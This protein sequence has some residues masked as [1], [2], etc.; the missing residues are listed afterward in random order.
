MIG[1]NPIASTTIADDIVQNSIYSS[2]SAICSFTASGTGL[3]GILGSGSATVGVSAAGTGPAFSTGSA[4][5]SFGASGV[6]TIGINGIGSASIGISPGIAVAQVGISGTGSAAIHV[7]ASPVAVA[8]ITGSGSA[9]VSVSSLPSPAT[10]TT[11]DTIAFAVNCRTMMGSEYSSF[12]F[13]SLARQGNDYFAAGSGGIYKL[14]G[15]KDI[16]ANIDTVMIGAISDYGVRQLKLY[17]D[18]HLFMRGEGELELAVVT[19]ETKKRLYPVSAREGQ[20]GAHT[21]R[22]RLARGIHG[23]TVQLEVRNVLGS[24]FD[25]QEIQLTYEPTGRT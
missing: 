25:L 5:V 12:P 20:Q 15:T 17:P 6:G 10:T 24:D 21:K 2:G 4:S 1:S 8:G 11:A 22:C 13:N 16:A 7:V 3:I 19:D 18:A 23:R 14:T 9:G